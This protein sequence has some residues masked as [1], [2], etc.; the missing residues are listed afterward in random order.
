MQIWAFSF[1]ICQSN[2]IVLFTYAAA[3]QA[4]TVTAWRSK[5]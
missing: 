4:A 2:L 1:F 5:C 3:A